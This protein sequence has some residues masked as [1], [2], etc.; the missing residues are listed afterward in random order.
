MVSFPVFYLNLMNLKSGLPFWLI[1][2]GLPYNYPQLTTSLTTNVVIVGGGISGALAAYYLLSSGVSCIVVDARTIG[3][4]STCASTSLLQYEL[5]A[6]LITL[7]KQIGLKKA[8]TA[9]RLCRNAIFKL[10]EIADAIGFEDFELRK[11]LYYAASGKTENLLKEEFKARKENGFAVEFMDEKEIKSC[12][13]IKAPAAI[14]SQDGGQTDA[15]LFTHA[16]LQ[17][18]IKNGLKVFDRTSIVKISHERKGVTLKTVDGHRIAAKKIVYATGYESQA[19]IKKKIVSLHSTYVTSSERNDGADEFWMQNSLIWNTADPY[20]YMRVTKDKRIIV[21]GRDV[22]FANAKR[23]DRLLPRKTEQLVS[24]FKKI[25]PHLSFIPEFSWT[26]TFGATEDALPFIGSY[27]GLSHGYFALEFG[28]N[29]ITFSLIA[30]AIITDLF[31]GKKNP[32]AAIF[33]FD[34]V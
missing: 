22:P 5:D 18:G 13:G 8:V 24:D 29:G 1:K 19:Y 11:S 4:G 10:G 27:P 12:Y 2:D 3:L 31:H 15:Y 17:H 32:D 21:G 28:G 33:S 34:R 25:F 26:G 9:Y 20:L 23:R 30:A 7:S 16:L 6:P 14:L